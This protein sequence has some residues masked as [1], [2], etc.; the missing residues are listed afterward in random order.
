MS[1]LILPSFSQDTPNKIGE[2]IRVSGKN[3][4]VR[5]GNG[6]R[7]A[8]AD[9]PIDAKVNG[10]KM[11]CVRVD[12]AGA[13]PHI[14]IGFTPLKTFD[15]QSQAAFGHWGF[16]GCGLFS[17]D[18][19]LCYPVEKCHN[20]IN[21]EISNT[22]REII[23]ILTISNNGKKKEIRFLCDG[24]ETKSTD[25][26][27]TLNEDFSFPA[28]VLWKKAQQVTAIPIDEIKTRTPEIKNLIKEYQ[29]QQQKGC[30]LLQFVSVSDFFLQKYPLLQ[31][32]E[33]LGR[34]LLQQREILFRGLMAR[35]N[36]EMDTK[37]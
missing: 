5:T 6:W 15:S 36:L 19:S 25:V 29:Q 18:G 8:I 28:I 16:T 22:A 33:D 24:T 27:E 17:F 37:K 13:M 32:H 21:E 11:F 26:S 4:L 35:M 9:E 1:S 34:I 7:A 30:P 2:G 3:T 31:Q 23:V 12:N 10:K 20:I 14:M